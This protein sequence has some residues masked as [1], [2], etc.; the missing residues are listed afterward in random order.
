MRLTRLGSIL[1]AA[2]ACLPAQTLSPRELFYGEARAAAPKK[3][4]AS[5]KPK[6]VAPKA[7]APTTTPQAPEQTEVATLASAGSQTPV[8]DARLVSA[9]TGPLGL[10]YSVLKLGPDGQYSEVDPGSNFTAGDQIRVS[11]E[12]NDTGYLYVVVQGS[13]GIWKVM[14]PSPEVDGGDNRVHEGRVYSLPSATHVFKFDTKTG[15]EKLFVVLSRQPETDLESLIYS[16]RDKA[17]ESGSTKQ[18]ELSRTLMASNQAPPIQDDVVQRL[19]VTY[20]R[21]L[22]IEK[23]DD[24]KT[25]PP[26]AIRRIEVKHGAMIPPGEKA[27]YVVNPNAGENARV[28]ANVELRHQ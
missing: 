3:Q 26:D 22:V 6:P 15:T 10:K 1:L 16:V 9:K 17:P 18:G 2:A 28:V 23:V 13:S 24:A 12:V 21:D 7:D 20:S 25:P 27:V 19:R 4:V 5:A 8:Q 11:V 14:Y